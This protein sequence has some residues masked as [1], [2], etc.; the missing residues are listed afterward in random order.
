[1]N[2]ELK[3]IDELI[4]EVEMFE[5]AG[6]YPVQD[7]IDN[8]KTLAAKVKEETKLEGCVVV[9]KDQTE[10]WYLD[11]NANMWITEPDEWLC[12]L[13]VGEVQSVEHKEYLITKSDTL[14]AAIV[15]DD[16]N[17]DSGTWEFFKTEEEAEKA[18][19]HCKAMLEAA[20]GGNENT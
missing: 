8:L 3:A 4:Y 11:D 12:D 10:D 15:W 5:Q 19:A 7:F 9:P 14:Y 17:Q 18:A 1:M 2:I 6:V 20:R 13:Y 16:E